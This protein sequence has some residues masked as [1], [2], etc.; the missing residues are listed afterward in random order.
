MSS[1]PLYFRDMKYLVF[2]HYLDMLWLCFLL[3]LFFISEVELYPTAHAGI[4]PSW[5]VVSISLTLMPWFWNSPLQDSLA[6]IMIL[7]FQ[8][9]FLSGPNDLSC[10]NCVIFLRFLSD[11]IPH[12]I[13]PE[14]RIFLTKCTLSKFHSF[15]W[16]PGTILIFF[17]LISQTK[18][19]PCLYVISVT[20][21]FK[22]SQWVP[23]KISL[24]KSK[25]IIYSSILHNLILLIPSILHTKFHNHTI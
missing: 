4:F 12:Q 11:P 22:T 2:P 6:L 8:L 5:H 20:L 24:V 15:A 1:L 13:L 14:L 19:Y 17:L 16:F 25:V 23:G 21:P 9:S 18:Q 10:A 3:F 7:L